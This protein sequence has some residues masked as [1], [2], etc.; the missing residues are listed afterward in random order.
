MVRQYDVL[1]T[2]FSGLTCPRAE[3]ACGGG[4]LTIGEYLR[5]TRGQLGLSVRDAGKRLKV[6][7]TR[8][9]EIEA[10]VSRRTGKAT[11]PGI[12]FLFKVAKGYNQPLPLLLEMAGLAP[13]SKDEVQEAE[14]IKIIRGLPDQDR[15]LIV[16]ILRAMEAQ[17][18]GKCDS[19]LSS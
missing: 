8:L 15:D 14:I 4:R 2:R 19:P 6:S 10:G 9:Q 1:A 7:Y 5:E 12:D 13:K 18:R 16:T 11:K 3:F 17:G